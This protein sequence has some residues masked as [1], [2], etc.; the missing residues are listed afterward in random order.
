MNHNLLALLIFEIWKVGDRF[1]MMEKLSRYNGPLYI[2]QKFI[3]WDPL[4][5]IASYF[6][7]HSRTK[8]LQSVKVWYQSV[9]GHCPPRK[10]RKGDLIHSYKMAGGANH[11]YWA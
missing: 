5:K 4:S 10:P 7:N 6:A 1:G 9:S 8:I 3:S 2:I 11:T